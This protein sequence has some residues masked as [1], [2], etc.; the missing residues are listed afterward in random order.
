[1]VVFIAIEL[2]QEI[3]GK[4]HEYVQ[5]AVKPACSGGRWV[6]KNNYHLT[7]KYIGEADEMDIDELHRLLRDAAGSS[8]G[9]RL[10]TGSVGV[11][12]DLR[13][14]RARVLWL[15]VTGDTKALSYLR[16][17]IENRAVAAGFKAEK[18]F[19]PHITLARDVVLSGMPEGMEKMKPKVIK[20]TSI[21][22]MESRQEKGRRIY[23][24]LAVYKLG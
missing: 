22:L 6:D 11:F 1:M 3:K 16:R 4:I 14:G 18:R 19:S 12:G 15:D 20:V 9:F 7:L 21:S 24:P 10:T 2:E 23:L 8:G 5:K 13:D 17:Y